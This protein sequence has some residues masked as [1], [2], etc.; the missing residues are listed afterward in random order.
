MPKTGVDTQRTG[1]SVLRKDAEEVFFNSPSSVKRQNPP[2]LSLTAEK[3]AIKNAIREEQIKGDT[4]AALLKAKYKKS[5][6]Y[7]DLTAYAK[8]P[9][10][11]PTINAALNGTADEKAKYV[12]DL[13]QTRKVLA[14]AIA[15][16]RKEAPE[17]CQKAHSDE[18]NNPQDALEVQISK[19]LSTYER[20]KNSRH[21]LRSMGKIDGLEMAVTNND[22][23]DPF[24]SPNP[25]HG[26]SKWLE[27]KRNIGHSE[28]GGGLKAKKLAHKMSS[29]W[30]E[31]GGTDV[32]EASSPR[33]KDGQ[34]HR[35][36]R[37]IARSL[38]KSASVPGQGGRQEQMEAAR[39]IHRPA[40]IEALKNGRVR[41]MVG[42]GSTTPWVLKS[43]EPPSA[44]FGNA[45]RWRPPSPR[46]T[47]GPN[48]SRP[49][50]RQ[51]NTPSLQGRSCGPTGD[52][53]TTR[54]Q[55]IC[56]CCSMPRVRGHVRVCTHV[57]RSCVKCRRVGGK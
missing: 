50:G 44:S 18:A 6:M 46:E 22:V 57:N 32:Y 37:N 56:G 55:Q 54:R 27:E 14:E 43:Q 49:S 2:A 40:E 19:E 48:R 24:C 47:T 1:R 51:A 42:D 34:E 17:V 38:K 15:R 10:K 11:P 35:V 30:H 7:A 5:E 21:R 45:V 41:D 4:Y 28:Q 53:G 16:W 12:P 26:L 8:E 33:I 39:Y 25:A 29:T 36:I 13:K 52:S 3:H 9:D 31:S 20:R 23:E